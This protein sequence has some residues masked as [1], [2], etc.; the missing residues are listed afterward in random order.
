MS[1]NGPSDVLSNTPSVDLSEYELHEHTVYNPDDSLATRLN[2]LKDQVTI[3]EQRAK[4][5]LT[6]RE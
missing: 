2:I 6:E 5:E 4:F 1:D 3:Y